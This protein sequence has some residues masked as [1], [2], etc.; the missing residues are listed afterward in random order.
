[1]GTPSR[2]LKKE[3]KRKRTAESRRKLREKKRLN[4]MIEDFTTPVPALVLAGS[5]RLR[6]SFSF[7]AAC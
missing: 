6:G 5:P 3:E 7:S 2:L 4:L 1:M